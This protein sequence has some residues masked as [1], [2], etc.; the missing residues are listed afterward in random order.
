VIKS[1]LLRLRTLVTWKPWTTHTLPSWQQI[2]FPVWRCVRTY[3]ANFQPVINKWRL[4]LLCSVQFFLQIKDI[5]LI[6][7]YHYLALLFVTLKLLF[8][9]LL[10]LCS[11][12]KMSYICDVFAPHPP[13][14]S[15]LTSDRDDPTLHFSVA[16]CTHAS[17][18]FMKYQ[19]GHPKRGRQIRMGTKNWRFS[20]N[21]SLYLR[22]ITRQWEC[23]VRGRHMSSIE[24]CHLQWS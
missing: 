23:W 5:W 21:I 22:H 24:W 16:S 7:N 6:T 15:W 14:T 1:Y 10:L 2:L 11:C 3:S 18:H 12:M 8:A 4:S 9:N 17:K 19:W 13:W 20:T